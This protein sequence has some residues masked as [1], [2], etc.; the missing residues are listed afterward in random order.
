[1]P[2]PASYLSMSEQVA[3][4]LVGADQAENNPCK[5][6]EPRGKKI[7]KRECTAG[8][9][10]EKAGELLSPEAFFQV[11]RANFETTP[12]VTDRD[13]NM[14]VPKRSCI[15]GTSLLPKST[16]SAAASHAGRGGQEGGFAQEH[17]QS[18]GSNFGSV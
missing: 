9:R 10:G 13:V 1:M 12:S 14:S 2:S 5:M 18:P 7:K 6:D 17:L 16:R 15:V 11:T 8:R 4:W 3:G